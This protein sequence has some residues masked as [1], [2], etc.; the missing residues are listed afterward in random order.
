MDLVGRIDAYLEAIPH[1][2]ILVSVFVTA[3]IC[4]RIALS[5]AWFVFTYFIRP[6]KKLR[7]YGEYAIVTGATDGIGKAYAFELAS[8]GTLV[9]LFSPCVHV[10]WVPASSL[11]DDN[12]LHVLI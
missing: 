7:R 2:V 4:V 9:L 8:A 10:F 12:H 1:A 11:Y 6:G 5:A 3:L